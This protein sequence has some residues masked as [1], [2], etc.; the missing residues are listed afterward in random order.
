MYREDLTW[1]SGSHVRKAIPLALAGCLVVLAI[2]LP[3]Q[4]THASSRQDVHRT[5]AYARPRVDGLVDQILVSEGCEVRAGQVVLKLSNTDLVHQVETL[6]YQIELTACEADLALGKASGG[7]LTGVG[8]RRQALIRRSMLEN[9]LRHARSKLE[10]LNV[11]SPVSGRIATA[12]LQSLLGQ[13]A[14]SGEALITI[15]AS[16]PLDKS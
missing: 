13:T 14:R 16:A 7:D 9:D 1:A 8:L 4:A 2:G 12:D 3:V 10:A 15:T 5:T 11:R 6:E